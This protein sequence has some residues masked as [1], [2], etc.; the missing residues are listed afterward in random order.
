[1]F[2]ESYRYHWKLYERDKNLH[3]SLGVFHVPIAFFFI[4]L[5][6]FSLPLSFLKKTLLFKKNKKYDTVQFIFT[7]NQMKISLLMNI[8][9]SLVLNFSSAKIKNQNILNFKRKFFLVLFLNSW[10]VLKALFTALYDPDLKFDL[11]RVIKLIGISEVAKIYLKNCKVVLQ[12]NDHSPYNV[13]VYDLAREFKLKSI[14]IQH[15]PVSNLF[16]PLYNDLNVLFS[17]DSIDKYKQ[18]SSQDFYNFRVIEFFDIRFPQMHELKPNKP[19]FV[20]ICYNILDDIDKVVFC[21]EYFKE[22]NF[23]VKVRPHPADNR[24]LFIDNVFVSR[25]TSIWQ[26]LETA[27][28]V[29]VNESAVPLESLYLNIPTFKLSLFTTGKNLYNDTYGFL[30]NGL[31]LKEYNKPEEILADLQHNKITWDSQCIYNYLGNI[32]CRNKKYEEFNKE[33]EDLI[34]SYDNER[35]NPKTFMKNL[36]LI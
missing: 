27:L 3:R 14:Y 2:R 21:A 24:K 16:P 5:S 20:L 29:I 18:I 7:N 25:N 32:N 26:D 28:F 31:F 8:E 22:K 9:N 13:L 17:K 6:F 35:V 30:K 34:K 19:E 12:Y 33:L 15:A 1:M 23:K 4:L 36:L 11:I 10:Q